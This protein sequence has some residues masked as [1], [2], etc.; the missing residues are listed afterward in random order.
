MCIASVYNF[1]PA[2]RSLRQHDF[3]VILVGLFQEVRDARVNEVI[4]HNISNR[5]KEVVEGRESQG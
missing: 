3:P 1:S 2:R 5:M 4:V